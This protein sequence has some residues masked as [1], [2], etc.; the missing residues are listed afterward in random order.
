MR[1]WAEI[2]LFV[3]EGHKF[4]EKVN[5]KVKF[6]LDESKTRDLHK[7]NENEKVWFVTLWM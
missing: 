3:K 7:D 6:D 1:I 5:V 4:I 2:K